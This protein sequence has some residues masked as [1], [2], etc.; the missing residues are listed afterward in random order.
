MA[1]RG[2]V[3]ETGLVSRVG[4]IC[5]HS[6]LHAAITAPAFTSPCPCPC[7]RHPAQLTLRRIMKRPGVRLRRWNRPAHLRRTS[8]SSRFRSSQ[9]DL[10]SLQGRGQRRGQQGA[11]DE[12][13]GSR[14]GGRIWDRAAAFG[15]RGSG[16][17]S[18]SGVCV[19]RARD[20]AG[21]GVK[22]G[23]EGEHSQGRAKQCAGNRPAGA[24]WSSPDELRQLGD[25]APHVGPALFVLGL[26]KLCGLAVQGAQLQG[27]RQV[28]RRGRGG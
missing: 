1:T 15:R 4:G 8:T 6:A 13:A 23:R 17:G 18:R 10:P 22:R 5:C 12:T 16:R 26:L 7:P 2:W 9:V 20:E 14:D 21:V 3:P 11:E 24:S 28:D 25:V 19:W 27:G